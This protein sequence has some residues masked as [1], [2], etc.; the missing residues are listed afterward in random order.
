MV[1]LEISELTK[2]IKEARK[3]ISRGDVYSHFKNPNNRYVIED[4]GFIEATDEVA[5]IYRPLYGDTSIVWI[6][7]L[8]IFLEE[9]EINGKKMP[10]FEKIQI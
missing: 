5:V 3:K 1:H 10:R 8:L 4:I 7:P 6:R 2:R 9:V